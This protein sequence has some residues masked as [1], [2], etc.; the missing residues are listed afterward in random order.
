VFLFRGDA[1]KIVGSE[2]LDNYFPKGSDHAEFIIFACGKAFAQIVGY[3][4][5]QP[6]G[7]GRIG[8]YRKPLLNRQPKS[9]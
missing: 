6:A 4:P 7:L 9:L 1:I 3:F 2:P 8:V 5:R